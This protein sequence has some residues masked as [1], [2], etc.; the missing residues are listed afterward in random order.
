MLHVFCNDFQVF[1]GV[2]ASV[3]DACFKCFICC[4]LY[5]QLLHLDVSNVD[6]VLYMGCAWKVA[7][8]VGDVRDGMGPL[9]GRSLTRCAS[10]IRALAPQIGRPC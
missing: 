6:Q 3:S 9:L 5:V 2:F 1:S 7:G 10:T 4:L 8:G